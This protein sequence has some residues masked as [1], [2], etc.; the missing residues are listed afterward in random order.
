MAGSDHDG[1]TASATAT[2]EAILGSAAVRWWQVT[3]IFEVGGPDA[4]TLLA[5][6]CTQAVD[7]IPVSESRPGLFLDAKA[8]I[9]APALVH[10]APDAPWTDPRTGEVV[11]GAP[12]VL[13]ETTPD[14]AE[15]LRAHVA[16]YKLRARATVTTSELGS[17]AVLG[18][19]HDEHVATLL[20]GW[21]EAATTAPIAQATSG[22]AVP[23]STL[24]GPAP[25][26]RHAVRALADQGVPLADP[27]TV[28]AQRIAAGV[29]GLHDLLPGRMPAEVGGMRDAVSLDAGCYLGQEPVAR[30]HYRGRANRTLRR[31]SAAAAPALDLT[32]QSEHDSAAL[33]L[34]VEGRDR[35]VGQLT[36]WS[37]HPDGRW[38]ALGVV[39]HEI[40]RG[41]VLRVGTGDASVTVD[42]PAAVPPVEAPEGSASAHG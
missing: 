5:G 30:L 19:D 16:R 15:A 18:P 27:A 40:E 17:I 21:D 13:L 25:A 28:E 9:I 32:G 12:R 1:T 4:V 7:R 14:L 34:R 36:T 8:S 3:T 23:T 20:A 6:L 24:V 39:R 41:D 26:C 31:V 35:P 37:E 10:R 22:A 38:V 42:E 29:A 33:A 2:L 11:E